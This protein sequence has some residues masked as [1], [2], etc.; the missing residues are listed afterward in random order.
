M[1][2]LVKSGQD[3]SSKFGSNIK[4]GQV[5]SCWDRSN[6][7]LTGQVKLG[8]VKS[9]RSTIICTQNLFGPKMHLRMEFDSGVGPT[10]NYFT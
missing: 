9:D 10:C 4:S 6:Q 3:R 5:R 7:V 1:S 8:L 2:G